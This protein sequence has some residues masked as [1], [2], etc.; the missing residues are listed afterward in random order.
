MSRRLEKITRTIRDVVSNV[1]ENHL[2][3][4]RIRGMSSITHIEL[5][6]DLSAAKIYLSILCDSRKDQELTCKAINNAK[7][8][9]RTRLASILT[10][11]SCPALS[12]YLDDSLKKGIETIRIL[13]QLQEEQIEK[14]AME[15]EEI[16]QELTVEDTDEE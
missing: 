7:G 14:K 5:A 13:D 9:I 11:R 6:A 10:T 2:S 3:D 16:E 12:F 4:P 15:S 8:F 1:I